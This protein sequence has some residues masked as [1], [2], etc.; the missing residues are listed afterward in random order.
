MAIEVKYPQI[1]AYLTGED[2]NAFNLI[3]IAKRAMR[4]GGV[5]EM[6]CS[7]FTHECFGCGSYDELLQ[8]IMKWVN[9]E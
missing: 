4:K 3:N 1:T 2:G 6:D 7:T 8:T 9:V 5:P